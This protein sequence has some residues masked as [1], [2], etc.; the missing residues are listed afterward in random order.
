MGKPDGV[1]AVAAVADAEKDVPATTQT[2]VARLATT[3]HPQWPNR[4]TAPIINQIT[5][6]FRTIPWKIGR[7]M[8]IILHL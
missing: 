4:M 8:C 5:H 6:R 3:P 7:A 1:A 2:P